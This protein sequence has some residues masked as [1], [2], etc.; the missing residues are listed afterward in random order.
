MAIGK[1]GKNGTLNE[2]GAFYS[3][4]DVNVLLENS[5]GSDLPKP[6]VADAGKAVVV[7]EDGKYTL[8]DGGVDSPIV[9]M[10][11]LKT[12]TTADMTFEEVVNALKADKIVVLRVYGAPPQHAFMFEEYYCYGFYD[13]GSANDVIK[14][15]RSNYIP[16]SD[17]NAN[18]QGQVYT[19][20]KDNTL[21]E[22]SIYISS[23][24]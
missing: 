11:M 20:H 4:Q 8:G 19:M 9:I 3:V 16:R 18:V 6:T 13:Y 15:Y 2:N 23:N 24:T 7:G 12:E 22:Q 5:G 10:K 21:T 14:F 1:V 17:E